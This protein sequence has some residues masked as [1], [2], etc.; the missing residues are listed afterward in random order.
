[1]TNL[2]R[3]HLDWHGSEEAYR[4]DKLRLLGLPG[5]RAAVLNA[6]DASWLARAPAAPSAALLRR[7]RRLGRRPRG[8]SRCAG[9]LVART[10][11]AAAAGRAQR[12][13]PVR[14][15]R[16]AR[17]RPASPR[18]RCRRRSRGFEALPHRL[19][20]VAERDGVALGRRQHLDDARV[21]RSPRSRASPSARRAD[22]RAAR[23]AART[24]PRWPASWRAAGR[25]SIGLPST[26]PRL[27]AAAR[28]A[29]C[30]RR[31]RS[32]RA[33]CER[34]SRSRA[35]WRGPGAVVLLSPAAPSYDHYRD[36]EERGERFRALAELR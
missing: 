2:F 14:R 36:F 11:R 29:G 19:Q 27:L 21:G 32:R 8:R 26:G 13:Q 20:T 3:E 9:E 24:T 10:R 31:A 15:A 7:A 23:T 34:P 33:G 22:R 5:V 4:A 28:A 18:R 17:S 6:R 35:S 30:R 16:G 25:P 12:A 1:M